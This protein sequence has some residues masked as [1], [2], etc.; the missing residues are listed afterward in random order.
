MLK[1]KQSMKKEFERL[2]KEVNKVKID[3]EDCCIVI[4]RDDDEFTENLYADGYVL[5]GNVRFGTDEDIPS[6]IT[7]LPAA[8]RLLD[9]QIIV[10]QPKYPD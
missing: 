5:V 9:G 4:A 1:I 7:G 3:N 2:S 10:Y 8:V 6:F